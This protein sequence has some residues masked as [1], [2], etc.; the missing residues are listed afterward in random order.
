[1]MV[2]LLSGCAQR[3]ISEKTIDPCLIFE[4]GFPSEK[5]TLLTILWFENHNDIFKYFC[6]GGL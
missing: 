5:D 2:I 3:V 6:L 1:M 4:M